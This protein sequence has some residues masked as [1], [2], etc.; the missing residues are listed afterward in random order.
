MLYAIDSYNI[1]MIVFLFFLV[2]LHSPSR[3]SR[4]LYLAIT[5]SSG[6]LCLRVSVFC[7]H[8]CIS[9]SHTLRCRQKVA[10]KRRRHSVCVRLI[11][12]ACTCVRAPAGLASGCSGVRKK[13]RL[14]ARRCIIPRTL[15]THV[16]TNTH[17]CQKKKNEE[18]VLR[19][20]SP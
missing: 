13:Q 5:W 1:F 18:K 10:H 7:T 2:I 16:R 17:F 8:E 9:H 12:T 19:G 15:Q 11:R 20:P 14:S 6:F 3:H 4:S